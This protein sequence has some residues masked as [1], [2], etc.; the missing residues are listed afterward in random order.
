MINYNIINNLTNNN[1][2]K[3]EMDLELD[4]STKDFSNKSF[5]SNS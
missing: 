3:F 4:E 1:S 5:Y 2:E